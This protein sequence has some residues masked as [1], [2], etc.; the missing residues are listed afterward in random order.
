MTLGF[1][2][3]STWYGPPSRPAQLICVQE[4]VWAR[5]FFLSNDDVARGYTR[6]KASCLQDCNWIAHLP[7]AP[8]A[9]PL[10]SSVSSRREMEETS[11]TWGRPPRW[12]WPVP[13]PTGA[14]G[15]GRERARRARN[16]GR[17]YVISLPTHAW[18]SHRQLSWCSREM[19]P[20]M[21]PSIR[22][23]IHPSIHRSLSWKPNQVKFIREIITRR[24]PSLKP[25]ES[26]TPSPSA[27]R[28]RQSLVGIIRRNRG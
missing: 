1:L 14:G 21:Q 13:W 4:R 26:G 9:V 3:V 7:P 12:I 24:G 6:Q 17:G 19:L 2:G 23:S 22:S 16:R 25:L 5:F 10:I 11:K 8:F 15:Y 18:H 28:R 20:S 27:P